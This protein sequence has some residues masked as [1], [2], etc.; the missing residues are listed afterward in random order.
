MEWK[1]VEADRRLGGGW[2][3]SGERWEGGESAIAELVGKLRV[4]PRH[5]NFEIVQD[6]GID[7]RQF[8][9]WSMNRPA[10]DS[11]AD[12]YEQRMLR[13][14]SR[15]TS[16]LNATFRRVIVGSRPIPAR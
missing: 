1:H 11:L 13:Q 2:R 14:L 10:V 7:D 8:G 12:L 15:V 6:V 3:S 9:E 5:A 16:A 4:D